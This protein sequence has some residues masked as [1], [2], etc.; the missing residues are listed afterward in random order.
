M[1]QASHFKC[2]VVDGSQP[3]MSCFVKKG[4]YNIEENPLTN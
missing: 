2:G 1:L 4:F 3:F